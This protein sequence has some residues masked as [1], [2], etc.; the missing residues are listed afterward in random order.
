MKSGFIERGIGRNLSITMVIGV[1][2]FQLLHVT[3]AQAAERI[4]IGQRP[5]Y[6]ADQL[7]A[8]DLKNDLMNCDISNIQPSVFS[9]GHRGAP[10]QF[11]EHTVESYIAAARMG[12]G[13]I[14]CDVTFTKDRELVC[15]HSQCDLHT[16]TNILATPLAEKCTVPPDYNS[17]S[18]FADV[19]CCTSDITL[20]EFKSLTGKMD[21]GNPG[22]E[23][24]EDY[25]NATADWRTD[26]YAHE[27]TLLSHAESIRLFDQL[28]VGMTPELKEALVPLPFDGDYTRNQQATQMLQ[29]YRDANIDP[30]RVWP[31]SFEDIDIA[32]WISTAPDFANQVVYLDDRYREQNFNHMNKATWEPTMQDLKDSGVQYLAPPL[33]M[34]VTLDEN[35]RM[36]PSPYAKAATE[37]G[38]KLIAWS[39][40]RSGP[41]HIE[42][43]GWYH[44]SVAEAMNNEGDVLRLL[45]VLARDVGVAGVFSDWPATTS[46][47]AHCRL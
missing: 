8:G 22:A 36:M 21:A 46:F 29:E 25:M 42:N 38:L 6:M 31:Q 30:A 37:A 13:I 9:I 34:L 1:I 40:E 7:P 44:Q 20:E 35:K 14:E 11:P 43:G 15:R 19:Q 12:A 47:Y 26:L 33:W 2:A 16:T 39:L 10:M 28:G 41:I 45:D 3:A 27:G 24:L 18:P 5:L 32:H 17:Q 23:N 4:S